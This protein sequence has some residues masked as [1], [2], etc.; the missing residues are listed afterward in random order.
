MKNHR[1]ATSC[2]ILLLSAALL[3]PACSKMDN[4]TAPASQTVAGPTTAPPYDPPATGQIYWLGANFSRAN[5]LG[6]TS[7]VVDVYFS[8][9]GSAESTDQVYLTSATGSTLIP[10]AESIT[11]GGQPYAHYSQTASPSNTLSYV[12][13]GSYTL[14]T[15]T[16]V[17]TA[18]A[19]LTAPGNIT[20]NSNGGST[21]WTVEGTNDRV[22]VE[23][24]G[25]S[26]T[27]D[28][29]NTQADVHSPFWVPSTAYPNP[30]TYLMRTT[31][32]TIVNTVNNA[33]NGSTFAA[34][35]EL[36][37]YVSR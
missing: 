26:G 35:D 27:Y 19:T 28:S 33:V 14:S 5:Q 25:Y 2:A 11:I 23:T 18:R 32:E 9:N 7:T 21:S 20:Q 31:C 29:L 10:Y 24:S 37:G 16:S 12:P 22:Y 34:K 1:S 6:Y 15:V 36:W 30:G 4:P 3:L 17:G 8:V 13:G